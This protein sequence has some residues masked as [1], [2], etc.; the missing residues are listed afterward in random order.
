MA[1]RTPD[2]M[3]D[4]DEDQ[5]QFYTSLDA[6][7]AVCRGKRRHK[8]PGLVP[9]RA[10]PRGIRITRNRGVYQVTEVC[11]RGCGR[12]ITYTAGTDGVPDYSTATYGG[13]K[14]GKQLATGLGLTAA[15]DH[16]YMCYIQREAVTEGYR[17]LAKRETE[18]A[19]QQAP[20]ATF[21]AAGA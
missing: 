19:A 18:A 13:W 6:E 7:A 16:A 11:E 20:A 4:L 3:R 15:D 12:T 17:L 14:P 21:Q 2:W 5:V 8:F 9:G 1:P 10:L